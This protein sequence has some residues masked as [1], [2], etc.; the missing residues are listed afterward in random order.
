MACKYNYLNPKK[1][2]I[3]STEYIKEELMRG[4]H[5]VGSKGRVCKIYQIEI[6]GKFLSC[7]YCTEFLQMV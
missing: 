1:T 5:F 7:F 4:T 6:D 3:V 2:D